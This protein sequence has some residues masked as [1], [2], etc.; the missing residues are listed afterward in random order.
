MVFSERRRKL[1]PTNTEEHPLAESRPWGGTCTLHLF[2][3]LGKVALNSVE[4]PSKRFSG[5]TLDPPAR[6]VTK[7]ANRRRVGVPSLPSPVAAP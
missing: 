4:A 1:D 6:Y 7:R 5:P 3:T 2:R